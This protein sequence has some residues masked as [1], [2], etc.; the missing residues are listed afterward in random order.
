VEL[1]GKRTLITG[2]ARGLGLAMAELFVERGARV[3]I[4]DIDGAGAERAAQELGDGS[5]GLQ[6]DV[7]KPAEVKAMIEAA[8]QALGGLDVLVN[9]AG[10]EIAKPMVDQTDEEFARTLDVNVNGTFYCMKYAVPA[11]AE[12]KGSIVNIS[13]AAGLGGVPLLA[14]YCASKGAVIRL[15]QTAATELRQAGIRVNAVC[16]SFAPTEM[17]ERMVAPIEAAT[18]AKM[19]DLIALKQGRW[20]TPE[21]IAEAVAFLAS[22]DATFVTGSSYILDNALS[23]AVL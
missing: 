5:V 15:T 18:G 13:S 9:N 21:E 17:V 10:I 19:E 2:A 6:A 23:A 14:A 7:T 22:D 12:S 11:L 8:V 16:P 20:C 3:A 1:E 4:A